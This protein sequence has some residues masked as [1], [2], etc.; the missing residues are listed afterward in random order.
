MDRDAIGLAGGSGRAKPVRA[1]FVQPTAAFGVAS[2]MIQGHIKKAISKCIKHLALDIS[3]GLREKEAEGVAQKIFF[4]LL[5]CFYQCKK[6][7]N[8]AKI[9]DRLAVVTESTPSFCCFQLVV[10]LSL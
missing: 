8:T 1:D 7:G 2:C 3:L 4:G 6:A 9:G 5:F 10:L